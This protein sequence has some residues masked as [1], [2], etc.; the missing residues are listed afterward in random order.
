MEKILKYYNKDKQHVLDAFYKDFFSYSYG[1]NVHWIVAGFLELIA[2]MFF[3]FPFYGE[4]SGEIR[5]QVLVIY[6]TVMGMMFYVKPFV[7]FNEN[8]KQKRLREKLKYLPVSSIDL[9]LYFIKR[10]LK[11]SCKLLP[12]FLIGQ[13]FFT[14]LEGTQFGLFTIIYPVGYGIIIPFVINCLDIVVWKDM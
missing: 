1:K 8:E 4:V 7:Y 9:K 11:F 2:A 14:Y 6:C 5:D 12:I 3:C 13:I 10:M